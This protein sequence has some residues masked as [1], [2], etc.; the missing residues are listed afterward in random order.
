MGKIKE[1]T[2]IIGIWAVILVGLAVHIGF[3]LAK[4]GMHYPDEI[5]QYLEP[6]FVRLKGCGWLPWE[7]DRGV[8][9]WV[10][11]AFYGGW[12]KVLMALGIEGM[13]LHRLIG[14]HNTLLSLCLVPAGFRLGY[15]F[16]GKVGAWTC[17]LLFSIFPPIVFFT[18]HPLSEVPSMVLVIW[19]LV[20]WIEGKKEESKNK[21]AFFSGLFLGFGA[22]IKFSSGI[23]LIVPFFD[24]L[25]RSFKSKRVFFFILGGFIPF[26]VLGVSDWVT[27]G[28]AFHS[29]IEYFRYNILEWRNIDHGVSPWWQYFQWIF[30]RLSWSLVIFIPLFI[31][32]IRQTWPLVLVSVVG[33]LCL[34][35]IAHK[36]ERFMLIFWPLFI[37]TFAAGL[38]NLL[39]IFNQR[40]LVSGFVS[41]ISIG[42]VVIYGS[43]GVAKLDWHWLSGYFKAQDYVG[44]QPDASGC[45]FY[46][47]IHLSGGYIYLN[48]NIP[49][50]SYDYRLSQNPL[51]NYFLFPEGSPY[52]QMARQQGWS[53]E[54]YFDGIYVFRR[55][56]TT[57]P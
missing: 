22:L 7:F 48:R 17:A 20:H 27:W 34:S 2:E 6:A 29:A 54:A 44:R 51:F 12:M 28:G 38:R 37:T 14:L 31:W 45:M 40:P 15:Y 33:M 4:S 5:F 1:K 57:Q 43:I 53:K 16:S 9:N 30:E 10:L 52:E 25:V 55:P 41:F 21:K 32:G 18:P 13:W 11:I 47:R 24:Y 19:G 50:F 36:E 3:W 56:E 8:R 39:S 49:M 26:I 42:L 23:F 35:L 46:E